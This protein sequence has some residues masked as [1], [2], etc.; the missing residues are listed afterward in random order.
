LQTD[1]WDNR[2]INCILLGEN[3]KVRFSEEDFFTVDLDKY[4]SFGLIDGS[5]RKTFINALESATKLRDA[6]IEILLEDGSIL[7]GGV[8]AAIQYNKETC[9]L[10][11]KWNSYFIPLVSGDMEAGKF[12]FPVV[13]MVKIPERRYSLY[14]LMEKNLYKLETDRKFILPKVEILEALRIDKD[15]KMAKTFKEISRCFIKKTLDDLYNKT[16]RKLTYSIIKENVEFKH[17]A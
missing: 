11:V 6:P 15:S 9:Y 5:K 4:Y 2:L 10:R 7:Y 14:L 12:L 17:E 1:V 3:Q 16:G 8:F 13:D